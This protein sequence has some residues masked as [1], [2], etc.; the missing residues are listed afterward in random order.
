MESGTRIRVHRRR[1]ENNP[2]T[3]C[4]ECSVKA[5]A[6]I[7]GTNGFK[8]EFCDWTTLSVVYEKRLQQGYYYADPSTYEPARED[9]E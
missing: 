9:D 2:A 5:V 3:V 6:A 1:F 7:P 8:V 4:C